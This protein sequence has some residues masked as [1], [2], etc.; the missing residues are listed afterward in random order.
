MAV[1]GG[2]ASGKSAVTELFS[3]IGIAVADAD[4]AARSI[5]EP[6]QPALEEI[7]ACFGSHFIVEGQLNRQALRELIF[8]NA[9]AKIKLESITHP[10]IRELLINQCKSATSPYAVVAIPLLAEGNKSHYAWIHRTIVVDTSR[11]I[12]KSRLMARDGISHELADKMLV[13]QASRTKRLAI[14]NDVITNVHDRQ[15]LKD[16]V[17]RLD[18]RYR[19]LASTMLPAITG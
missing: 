9:D 17:Q 14:A 3:D 7:A 15:S 2:I 1:T 12:Q 13:A 8:D 18:R 6:R 11:E 19:E 16:S 10:R 4:L 5:V